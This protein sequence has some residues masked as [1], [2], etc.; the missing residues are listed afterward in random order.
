MCAALSAAA[1]DTVD[2]VNYDFDDGNVPAGVQTFDVDGAELHFLM[3][4]ST[5][6]QGDSWKILR[7]G[8]NRYMA[9]PSMA[10]DGQ[11]APNDWLVTPM[12]MVRGADAKLT[13][14][15][16]SSNE[17]SY[18]PCAYKVMLSV[19]SECTPTNT[20]AIP[21]K[22]KTEASV[23]KWTEV[24]IDLKQWAGKRVSIAFVNASSATDEILAVDNIRIYGAPGPAMVDYIPGRYSLGG[25][26]FVPGVRV[27]AAS[28]VPVNSVELVC[29]IRGQELKA[30]STGL[31]LSKGESTEVKIDHELPLDLGDSVDYTMAVT[32]NGMAYDA[33]PCTT[34]A[35]SFLPRRKVVLE[36]FTG[37]WCGWC[38]TAIVATDSL[39]MAYGDQIIP[40]AIHTGGDPMAYE[41]YATF[42][43]HAGEAPTG[44]FDRSFFCDTPLPTVK[45]DR[46][47]CYTMR[48]GFGTYMERALS[49]PSNAEVTLTAEQQASRKVALK[50]VTRF[51]LDLKDIDYRMVFVLIEDD[52]TGNPDLGYEQANYAAQYGDSRGPCG[53]YEHMPDH[54]EDMHFHHVARAVISS[55]FDGITGVIPS[56]VV[57][58][59]EYT[60]TGSIT[61][62]TGIKP[63]NCGVVA[64]LVDNA[65]GK[66]LN[67]DV[68]SFYTASISAVDTLG[69]DATPVIYDLQ[70]RRH[71]EVSA[72]GIYI[73]N[74]VKTLVR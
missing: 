23:N 57:G 60:Y 59:Q 20:T 16:M 66:V 6:A 39:K 74:G 38:T 45:N 40:I 43:G 41:Q 9:S 27:T 52:V 14:S 8:S 64:M 3:K 68:H 26:K 18:A 73:I 24:T 10:A 7:D 63:D 22:G 48:G 30:S 15:V 33:V 53:G 58:G 21:V 13:F 17:Q 29:N 61:V 49:V 51:A 65:T 2:Y 55:K 28:D 62:P 47:D 4:Q 71:Q 72:P 37:T 5:F 69:D 34:T 54:I 70:G 12:I 36:E 32:V 50:V 67:A 35:L 1:A 42:L 56:S 19:D 44:L 46:K 11:T 25:E 31:N